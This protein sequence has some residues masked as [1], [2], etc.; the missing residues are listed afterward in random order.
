M[1]EYEKTGG[2]ATG[3]KEFE[4][5]M[6]A[7]SSVL[8]LASNVRAIASVG[9]VFEL[10]GGKPTYE[11]TVTVSILYFSFPVFLFLFYTVIRKRQKDALEDP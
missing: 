2:E 7:P 10:S 1:D 8:L 11:P 5:P 3:A 9:C 6:D 4:V